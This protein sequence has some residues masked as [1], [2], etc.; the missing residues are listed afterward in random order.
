M[1]KELINLF[2]FLAICFVAYLLFKGINLKEGMTSSSP[3]NG[4]SG[5][6]LGGS[7]ASYAATIKAETVKMQDTFL[8][9][10]YRKDYENVVLNL[11]DL[12]SSLMLQTALTVD[13]NNPLPSLTKISELNQTKTALNNVMKFIDSSSS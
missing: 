12:I 9:S 1:K 10:K 8:I 7:A 13:T 2:L 11:D 4:S 5:N 6:G 3:T